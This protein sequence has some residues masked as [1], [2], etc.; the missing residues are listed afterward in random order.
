MTRA[1]KKTV[2]IL[3]NDPTA[4]IRQLI[5]LSRKL[6]QFADQETNALAMGDMMRFA[7]SQQDKEKLAQEYTA[8]SEEFRARLEQFRGVDKTLLNE[9]DKLQSELKKKS[10][11]NNVI[12]RQLRDRAI[13]NTKG[14]LFAAQELGQRVTFPAKIAAQQQGA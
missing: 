2:T 14:T 4:A 13:T 3:S 5:T 1:Q 8:A 12:I 11:D 10:E 6:C 9:L 7:Y